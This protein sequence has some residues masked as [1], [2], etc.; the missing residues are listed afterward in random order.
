MTGL[1]RGIAAIAVCG[2]LLA[3][4]CA[5]PRSLRITIGAKNFTEQVVLGE[6]LAQE[7]EAVTGQPVER[8]I[9]PGGQLSVPAGPGQR[10][11]RRLRGIHGNSADGDSE[12]AAA[13]GGTEG[14]GAG[15][16]GGQT[17]IR[18]AV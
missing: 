5:P 3:V 6:L 4:S 1:R 16:C 8:R 12:A 9:L 14:A 17:V 7:I 18:A 13:S 11:H 2:L 15:L 10:T